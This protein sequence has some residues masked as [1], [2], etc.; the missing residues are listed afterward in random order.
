[1]YKFE[2]FSQEETFALAYRLARKLRGG[3]LIALEGDL[4]AGKTVFVKGLAQGLGIEEPVTSPTFSLIHEYEGRIS[5]FH[6]DVYRLGSPEEIEELGYEE[7]FYGPGVTAVE[8]SDLITSHLPQEYLTVEIHRLYC[9]TRGDMR[10]ITLIPHGSYFENMVK[11]LMENDSL[12][13]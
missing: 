4:G 1:M 9:Q 3:E 2:T 12:G 5:L 10:T 11:E 8:W 7:Y 6:F 13:D